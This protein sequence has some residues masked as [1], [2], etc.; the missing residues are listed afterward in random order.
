MRKIKWFSLKNAL[1]TYLALNKV[2]YWFNV[3]AT[4]EEPSFE[5]LASAILTR[6]LNQDLPLILGIIGFMYLDY[7]I[8]ANTA[9][10]SGVLGYVKFYTIGYVLLNGIVFLY[11]FFGYLFILRGDF[12]LTEYMN[13][14]LG[15]LPMMTAFYVVASVFL[16]IKQYMKKKEKGG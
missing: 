5:I 9:N 7:R 14:Y 1:F 8:E 13:M 2:F 16:E 15:Y 6:M 12:V 11:G 4:F 10:Q 3:A